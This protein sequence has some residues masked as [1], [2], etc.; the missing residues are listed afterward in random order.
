MELSTT[1]G[2]L[3]ML[4]G[5]PQGPVPLDEVDAQPVTR[6]LGRANMPS[7]APIRPAVDVFDN[8]EFDL[9]EIA[10]PDEY[11]FP[12]GEDLM[13]YTAE[14]PGVFQLAFN[15]YGY[16]LPFLLLASWTI[17]ALW[18]LA[19]RDDVSTA[20]GVVWALVVLVVPF[21]GAIASH[22]F[23]GSKLPVWLRWAVIAG[24]ALAYLV[25]FVAISLVGGVL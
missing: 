24:G 11:L 2:N 18:D 13:A 25:T 9:D 17:L 22:L 16:L 8:Y 19:R 15:L 12:D 3:A 7:D 5:A 14:G 6:E 4:T 20:R 23:G 1:M 10:I 21:L